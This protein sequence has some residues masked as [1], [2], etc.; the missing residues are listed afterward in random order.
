MADTAAATA[1]TLMAI[2]WRLSHYL[3][4]AIQLIATSI[5]GIVLRD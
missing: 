1:S 3:E 5:G 4:P 2:T